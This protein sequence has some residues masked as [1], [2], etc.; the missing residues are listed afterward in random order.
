MVIANPIFSEAFTID[1]AELPVRLGVLAYT[2]Q[3]AGLYKR[4]GRETEIRIERREKE[5]GDTMM[6]KVH[7][8]T[9]APYNTG[10]ACLREKYGE[11]NLQVNGGGV[12]GR[13]DVR[14]VS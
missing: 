11:R 7:R 1:T 2:Q 8:R 10:V 12:G 14:K 5:G 13:Y 4:D 9:C 6:A 3:P